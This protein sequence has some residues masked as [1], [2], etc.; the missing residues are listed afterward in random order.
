LRYIYFY[1]VSSF[2]KKHSKKSLGFSF[3]YEFNIFYH[4]KN[5]LYFGVFLLL[6]DELYFFANYFLDVICGSI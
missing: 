5:I 6:F 2:N 4:Y 3:F 1:K